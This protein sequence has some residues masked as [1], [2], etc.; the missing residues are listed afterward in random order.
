[1][2]TNKHAYLIISHNEPEILQA[3]FDLIDDERNDVFLVVDSKSDISQFTYLRIKKSHF[4]LVPSVNH[5]WG[6]VLQIK[7]EFALFEYAMS[8]GNYSYLHL[9]SGVDLPLKSQDYIH[10]F[11]DKQEVKK[12]F[13][14][15]CHTANERKRLMEKVRYFYPFHTHFRPR[16]KHARMFWRML[17][18][19]LMFV[20]KMLCVNRMRNDIE[21]QCGTNW[22]S[23]TGDF[24]KYLIEHKD[25]M[26]RMYDHTLCADE[27]FVQ[28]ALYNSEFRDR[29]Y[30]FDADRNEG[31]LRKIDWTRGHPYVWRKEDLDELLKSKAL[32]ARK[33]SSI[34]MEVV[35]KVKESILG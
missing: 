18:K 2:E 26:L 9:L 35:N 24:C 27:I 30:D 34:D 10:D 13:V 7:T 32:F 29:I 16:G 25:E 22:I 8:K 23:I 31:C 19:P 6:S 5:R 28:T 33:F 11:L 4:Y 3:L 15:F 12:E 14:G 20:Q 17:R 21:Y 1:M